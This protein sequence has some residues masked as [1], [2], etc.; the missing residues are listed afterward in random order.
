MRITLSI[1]VHLTILRFCFVRCEGAW[2][3]SDLLIG[4]L[5]GLRLS[6]FFLVSI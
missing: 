4:V 1:S 6:N 3:L 2:K 5:I